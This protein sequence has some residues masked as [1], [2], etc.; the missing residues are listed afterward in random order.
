MRKE[1]ERCKEGFLTKQVD[2][3]LS[4]SLT[5]EKVYTDG[6]PI[7]YARQEWRVKGISD[8]V[9]NTSEV[10]ISGDI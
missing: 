10:N 7:I 2:K 4:G 3:K 9:R 1:L 5:R 8:Q 6:K